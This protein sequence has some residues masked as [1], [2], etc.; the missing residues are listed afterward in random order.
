MG[1]GFSLPLQ[2]SGL[3]VRTCCLADHGETRCSIKSTIIRP[4]SIFCP[5]SHF[6]G[7][8]L[9]SQWGD[10]FSPSKVGWGGE[11]STSGHYQTNSIVLATSQWLHV[12]ISVRTN[13]TLVWNLVGNL[14]E[15]EDHR[16][17]RK[18]IHISGDLK[19][20]K[21]MHIPENQG[22]KKAPVIYFWLTLRALHK[23]KVMAKAVL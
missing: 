20:C 11:G 12:M 6:A 4:Q 18:L 3:V 9:L 10:Y 5:N 8:S 23:P 15:L 21:N 16:D 2:L 13:K 19:G 14:G 1:M 17:F 22:K 7:K